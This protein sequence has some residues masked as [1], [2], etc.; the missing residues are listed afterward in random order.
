MLFFL[1]AQ[2]VHKGEGDRTL[3]FMCLTVFPTV[4]LLNF[5][6]LTLT[7]PLF[8]S[9]KKHSFRPAAA[10]W[11]QTVFP[12][13]S[14]SSRIERSFRQWLRGKRVAPHSMALRHTCSDKQFIVRAHT[15][16]RNVHT[17]HQHA[18]SF[19]SGCIDLSKLSTDPRNFGVLQQRDSDDDDCDSH[20][21]QREIANRCSVGKIKH[22]VMRVL[23]VQG[24]A[25]PMQEL[26]THQEL[27]GLRQLK[28]HKMTDTA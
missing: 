20:A 16:R 18:N 11:R 4:T 21:A 13:E 22:L 15:P 10:F 9:K 6:P 26:V 19:G 3:L 12:L 17:V 27:R 28:H 7:R 5:L 2:E 8:L 24:D 1:F 25:I 23:L 14:W